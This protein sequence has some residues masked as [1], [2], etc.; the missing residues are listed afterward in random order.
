MWPPTDASDPLGF[1]P[2][3][4]PHPASSGASMCISMAESTARPPASART[5]NAFELNATD[6]PWALLFVHCVLASLS[7]LPSKLGIGEEQK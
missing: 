7:F 4:P 1:L 2:I 3:C 6:V 5:R